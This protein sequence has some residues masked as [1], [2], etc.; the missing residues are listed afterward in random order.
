MAAKKESKKGNTANKAR[1]IIAMIRYT[2]SLQN[3]FF[4]FNMF[5]TQ[6]EKKAPLYFMCHLLYSKILI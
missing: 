3:G 5:Q 2:V 6:R 4:S 1:I